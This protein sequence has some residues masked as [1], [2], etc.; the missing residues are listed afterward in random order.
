MMIDI[1][2]IRKAADY[3]RA[4]KQMKKLWGAKPGSAEADALDVL[5]TLIDQFE[6]KQ[7]PIVAP[8]PIEAIK[9]RMEQ[10][11]LTRK[12]MEG[13]IGNRGRITEVLSG[14]RELTLAMIRRLHSELKIPAEVLIAPLSKS[15]A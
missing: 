2:P 7:F 13:I 10:L 1:K 5:A 15:A 12:D 11:A 3:E 4:L 8:E 6:S 14:K 9:F